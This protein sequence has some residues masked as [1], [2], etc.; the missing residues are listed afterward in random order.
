MIALAAAVTLPTEALAKFRA[1]S[2]SFI[3]E[4]SNYRGLMSAVGRDHGKAARKAG[5]LTRGLG[6]DRRPDRAIQPTAALK[7]KPS[8]PAIGQRDRKADRI[9]FAVDTDALIDHAIGAQF[10]GIATDTVAGNVGRGRTVP[11]G[12]SGT[13]SAW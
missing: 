8:V 5:H 13:S 2:W 11:G 6:A 9:G 4:A 3:K 7:Q 10:D 12:A 1:A